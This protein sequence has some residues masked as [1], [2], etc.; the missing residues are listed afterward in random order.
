MPPRKNLEFVRYRLWAGLPF[1]LLF[2]DFQI[3]HPLSL[4]LSSSR[5]K[6]VMTA[7]GKFVNHGPLLVVMLRKAEVIRFCRET[8]AL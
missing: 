7:L 2:V 6:H 1:I 3:N 8:E 4:L 5:Q